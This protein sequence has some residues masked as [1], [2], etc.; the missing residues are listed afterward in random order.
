VKIHP[1]DNASLENPTRLSNGELLFPGCLF[2]P[3]PQPLVAPAPQLALAQSEE[4][5]LAM[6]AIPDG[7]SGHK[8]STHLHATCAFIA[9]DENATQ[10][11]QH[12]DINNRPLGL[13]EPVTIQLRDG[14][15]VMLMRAEW[16]GFLWR[17]ES[18]DNGRTW[19]KAWQTDIPNPTTH[20]S[21]IRLPDG[22]IALIHNNAGK[23]GTRGPRNPMSIWVSDDELQSWS[24]KQDVI[25]SSGNPRP[26]KWQDTLDRLAYPHAQIVNGK[27]VFVYDRNRRDAMYVE[28]EL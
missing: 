12:G 4:E 3:R 27:L 7:E 23:I 6:P 19:T 17:A 11:V 28:V 1:N 14:R 26:A 21:L 20:L 24:I 22:R 18:S 8:F 9:P 5:A 2:H 25:S 13:L 15:V 16:G 10:L